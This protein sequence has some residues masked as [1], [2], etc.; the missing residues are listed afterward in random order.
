MPDFLFD[1]PNKLIIEPPGTG[2]TVFEVGR[3][4]YSAWKRYVQSGAGAQWEQAFVVE[5]GT[6]IGTTG[7]FTGVTFILVNGWKIQPANH[8]HQLLINGNIFSADGV[9]TVPAPSAQT[10]VVIVSSVNA[11]GVASGSGLSPAQETALYAA[12]DHARAANAQTQKV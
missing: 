7:L 3:D 4:I 2:D 5:G 8:D 6:P 12:R 9:V 1:G 10:N 11:Q